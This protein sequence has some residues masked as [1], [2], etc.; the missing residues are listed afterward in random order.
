MTEP[1]HRFLENVETL[2]R[3]FDQT[4]ATPAPGPA[5]DA[6]EFLAI[7]V[8]T[9]PFALR[10]AELTRIEARRK[11]VALPAGVPDLLGLAGVQG[12]L[13]PIYSLAALLGFGPDSPSPPRE[14]GKGERAGW[15]A[16]CGRDELLGLAFD[17]LEG[18]LR[19]SPPDLLSVGEAGP[20]GP[21]VRQ[22]VREAETVRYVVH[23]PAIQAL[24]RRHAGDAR[25]APKEP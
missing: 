2:R 15:I 16:V 7:R 21:Q 22:A 23:V 24:I 8:A 10:A 20:A 6:E 19:V 12:K 9:R 11:V 17:T 5:A 4:F 25:N 14:R 3:A 1:G 13:V 18:Y